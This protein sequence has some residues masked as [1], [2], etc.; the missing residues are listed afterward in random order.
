M[1]VPEWLW[2]MG[3]A[4]FWRKYRWFYAFDAVLVI[5]LAGLLAGWWL[6]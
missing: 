4:W 2:P 5:F 3:E 1:R 6:Q